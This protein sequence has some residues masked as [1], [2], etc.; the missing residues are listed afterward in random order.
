MKKLTSL[1]LLFL[2]SSC[3]YSSYEECLYK[4]IKDGNPKTDKAA[5]INKYAAE[6]FCRGK[7]PKPPKP[8]IVFEKGVDYKINWT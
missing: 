2:I 1:I 7:F 5:I 4:E 6:S 8:Q 3:G